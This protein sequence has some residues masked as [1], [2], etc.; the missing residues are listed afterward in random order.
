[1]AW[2]GRS[3]QPY[4][5]CAHPCFRYGR[6]GETVHPPSLAS[7]PAI[8]QRGEFLACIGRCMQEFAAVLDGC[9][10]SSFHST[11][12]SFLRRAEFLCLHS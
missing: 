4:R 9:N 6:A 10:H 7:S 8:P 5:G 2:Q 12:K 3:T 11:T 1:M